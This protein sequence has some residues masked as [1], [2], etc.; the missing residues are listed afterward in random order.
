[1]TMNL[2]ENYEY[3]THNAVNVPP[4]HYGDEATLCLPFSSVWMARAT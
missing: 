1:M 2:T 3:M 4:A